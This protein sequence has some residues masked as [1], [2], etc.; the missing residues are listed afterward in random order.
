MGT[1]DELMVGHYHKRLMVLTML[2][3]SAAS[4]YDTYEESWMEEAQ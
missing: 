3:G 1:T 2:F 4:A